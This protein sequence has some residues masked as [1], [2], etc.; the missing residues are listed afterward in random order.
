MVALH[1]YETS[2]VFAV[3]LLLS[4]LSFDPEDG[5]GSS[6][7]CFLVLV[8]DSENGVSAFLRNVRD[9]LLFVCYWMLPW[10]CF[11]PE[12]QENHARLHGVTSQK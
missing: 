2:T 12:H 4:L 10:Q 9:V 3:F 8:F 7:D 11:L 5:G 6:V 1:S